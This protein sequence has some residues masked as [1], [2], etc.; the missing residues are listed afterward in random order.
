MKSFTGKTLRWDLRDSILEVTLDREPAN[1]IGTAMLGELEQ[2]VAAFPAI[3]PDTSACIIGSARKHGFPRA[4]I[5]ESS[6]TPLRH[7]LRR[8]A[9]EASVSF[10]NASTRY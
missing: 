2:F 1:E 10:W 6:T 7:F 8:S 4:P 5:C 3:A 9:S